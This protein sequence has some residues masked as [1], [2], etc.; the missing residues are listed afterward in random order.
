MTQIER[1]MILSLAQEE[2][3]VLPIAHFIYVNYV[4][5]DEILLW[6]LKNN[7]KGKKLIDWIKFKFDNSPLSA[8]NFILARINH[9]KDYRTKLGRD[10]K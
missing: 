5:R 2:K 8:I 7:I 4:Q 9:D 3:E 10:F 1:D 6:L